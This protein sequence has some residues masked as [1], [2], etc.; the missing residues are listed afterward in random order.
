MATPHSGPRRRSLA[1]F[2]R[3]HRDWIRAVARSQGTT[4]RLTDEDLADWV[5][6]DERLYN[7]A[8]RLNVYDPDYGIGR[9]R[10]RAGG[11]S[12]KPWVWYVLGTLGLA[13]VGGYFYINR[14]RV[15][16]IFR[17]TDKKPLAQ[18]RKP[19]SLKRATVNIFVLGANF[20][21]DEL[22]ATISTNGKI[23][24]AHIWKRVKNDKGKMQKWELVENY[25]KVLDLLADAG[26][27]PVAT[28]LKTLSGAVREVAVV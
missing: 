22:V 11:F 18:S 15:V 24:T 13:G 23:E 6:N 19:M 20:P 25:K 9:L 8:K 10:G 1:A 7:E 5:M 3:T 4:G 21:D 12:M 17:R 27:L 16:T 28:G 26:K 2:V 14:P